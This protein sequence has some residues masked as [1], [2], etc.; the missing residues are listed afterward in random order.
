MTEL[1]AGLLTIAGF[2]DVNEE[3][4]QAAIERFREAAQVV[5]NALEGGEWLVGDRFGVADLVCAGVLLYARRFELLDGL[6]R[7]D[8]YLSRIE[9]RPARQRAVEITAPTPA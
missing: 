3:K 2:R 5:E 4:M 8:D 1:E 9:A 7:I 6:P